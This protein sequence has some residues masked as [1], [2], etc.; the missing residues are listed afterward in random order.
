MP[1][2]LRRGVVRDDRSEHPVNGTVMSS[3]GRA[4]CDTYL[5]GVHPSD[6]NMYRLIFQIYHQ[7]HCIVARTRVIG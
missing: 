6:P 3:A 4:V 7:T 2:F 1:G 5:G